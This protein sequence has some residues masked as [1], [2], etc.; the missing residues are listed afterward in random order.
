[1]GNRRDGR[2]W[3]GPYDWA[4][5]SLGPIEGWSRELVAIVN[6]TLC[7]QS[8]RADLMGASDLVLIYNDSYRSFPGK[9][10]PEALGKPAREVYKEA[11]PVVGPL[12]ETAFATGETFYFDKLLVPLDAGSGVRDFYLDYSFSPGL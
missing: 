5:T 11:W 10:H 1:V 3:F 6:L 12:L 2:G 4:S 9:R 8:P 7:S